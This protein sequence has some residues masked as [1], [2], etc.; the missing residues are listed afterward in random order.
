MARYE[1][2]DLRIPLAYRMGELRYVYL[3]TFLFA[4]AIGS[5]SAAETSMTR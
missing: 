2:L 3:L 4:A 1:G 5:G